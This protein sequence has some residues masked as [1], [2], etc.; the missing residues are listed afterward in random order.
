M[1][2]FDLFDSPVFTASEVILQ[3]KMDILSFLYA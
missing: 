1:K 3:N 2:L